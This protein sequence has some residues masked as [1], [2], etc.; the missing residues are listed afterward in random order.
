M[1]TLKRHTVSEKFVS[2]NTG[3]G[4]V[5][6]ILAFLRNFRYFQRELN[7]YVIYVKTT[8]CV[9]KNKNVHINELYY[10]GTDEYEYPIRFENNRIANNFPNWQHLKPYG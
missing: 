7:C 5:I 2:L 10:S 1:G 4:Y 6:F 9:T 3:R 8:K